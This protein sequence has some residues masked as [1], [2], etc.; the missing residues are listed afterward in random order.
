MTSLDKSIRMMFN[1]DIVA[2]GGLSQVTASSSLLWCVLACSDQLNS[3]L[4]CTVQ[5][6]TLL[7]FLLCPILSWP[8]LAWPGLSYHTLLFLLYNALP[9]PA[10]RC[11]ILPY[12]SSVPALL[13]IS[14]VNKFPLYS[15]SYL[16]L[17]LLF[18]LH[19]FF[20]AHTH[21]HTL[22]HAHT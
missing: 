6:S 4:S 10:L 3:V 15:R 5:C 16:S 12:L 7:L 18:S 21:T 14:S 11:P 13:L 8:D 9:C 22:T 20:L 2:V 1:E 19:L 17:S